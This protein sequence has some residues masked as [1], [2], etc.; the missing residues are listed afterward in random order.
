M[1]C[2]NCGSDGNNIKVGIRSTSKGRI[3]KYYCRDCGKYFSDI[4]SPKTQYPEHVILHTLEMYNRGHPVREARKLT[5]KRYHYSPPESTIYTWIDRYRD[6]LTFLKLRKKFR[7]YPEN[8]LT[9][10]RLD[11]GQ[12]Y[13]FKYH[14]LKLNIHSK[15]RPELRRYINWIE[16]SMDHKMFM[17]GPRAST[18]RIEH[19]ATVKEMDSTIPE[20]TR[21]ALNS[22][23]KNSKLTPHEMVEDFFLINDSST[24]TT[25]LPVFLYPQETD[26]DI[27]ES[28]TG[29]I[30]LIRIRYDNIHILDYKPNL[31]HPEN[32]ASQLF[33]YK[34]AIKKRTSI[35]ENKI[36]TAVFNE[37][38]YYEF[39]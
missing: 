25:E 14:N 13:P 36:R 31:N 21:M 20:L 3:Q 22:K 11:H 19:N 10:R 18:T 32:H 15:S 35:P 1:R 2:R 27:D 4:D 33:L 5:G 23:P 34:T 29:H 16:R 9:V 6:S 17:K 37:H 30:D 24:V 12:I 26:L 8:L 39:E 38:G 28:L 7:M